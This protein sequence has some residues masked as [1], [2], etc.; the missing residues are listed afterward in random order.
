MR[1][2]VIAELRS[3]HKKVIQEIRALHPCNQAG[4]ESAMAPAKCARAA[5]G[6]LSAAG[7]TAGSGNQS[8]VSKNE[9]FSVSTTHDLPAV[10]EPDASCGAHIGCEMSNV[11]LGPQLA[12]LQSK[13]AS[14]ICNSTCAYESPSQKWSW[15]TS[16][17]PRAHGSSMRDVLCESEMPDALRGTHIAVETSNALLMRQMAVCSIRSDFSTHGKSTP[18]AFE[19]KEQTEGHDVSPSDEDRSTMQTAHGSSV[20]CLTSSLKKRSVLIL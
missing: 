2:Q 18:A 9:D 7:S 19:E 20:T 10:E 14:T 17:N 8:S 11:L 4:T 6:A 16:R 3:E 12:D 1:D 13:S 15:S 5:S